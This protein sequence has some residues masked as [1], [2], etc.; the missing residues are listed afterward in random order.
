ML[1]CICWLFGFSRKYCDSNHESTMICM[2]GQSMTDPICV[3]HNYFSF[4]LSSTNSSVSVGPQPFLVGFR[5]WRDTRAL[6]Y[7]VGEDIRFS[8]GGVLAFFRSWNLRGLLL[9]HS[10]LFYCLQLPFKLIL[11]EVTKKCRGLDLRPL[12]ISKIGKTPTPHHRKNAALPLLEH[13]PV[14]L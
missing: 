3:E 2:K 9:L 10:K 7:V 5:K 12:K 1:P 6:S 4:V 13:R 11:W 14:V 8:D